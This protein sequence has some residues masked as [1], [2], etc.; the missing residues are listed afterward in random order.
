MPADPRP[1]PQ[2]FDQDLVQALDP[3][4]LK[5]W[6][7]LLP[8]FQEATK[9]WEWDGKLH[10]VPHVWGS[11][12]ISWRTDKTKLEYKTL[13]FGTMWEDQYKGAVQGRPHSMLLG[14]GLW[15]DHT[16]KLPSNRMLDAFKDPD[17]FRKLYDVIIKFAVDHKPWIKQFWDSADNTKSGLMQNGVII[18]QTWD[19]PPL[20]P[21]EGR[22]ACELH[23]ST[24]GRHH[25]ARWLGAC[26]RRGERGSGLRVA[27][28]PPHA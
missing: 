13:S 20:S 15:M 22:Q 14:I 25:L 24:G 3:K 23:G 8:S 18:G 2:F 17:T 5:S 7:N 6:N 9:L 1:P 16:G 11:E 19:G 27:R 12:A 21:Q 10:W 26:H 4:K 28:L